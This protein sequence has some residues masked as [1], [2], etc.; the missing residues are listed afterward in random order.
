MIKHVLADLAPIRERRAELDRRPQTV[1][2]VLADGNARAR[3]V[4]EQTMG[5]VREAMKL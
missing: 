3:A 1:D 2:E 5:E 4:A